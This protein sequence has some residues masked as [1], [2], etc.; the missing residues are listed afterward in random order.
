MVTIRSQSTR[1]SKTESERMERASDDERETSFPDILSREQMIELDSD[2]L[3]NRQRDT[4]RDVIDQRFYE[5]NRQIGELTNLVLALTLQ[6]SSNTREGNG[7]N[8]ATSSAN[9]HSETGRSSSTFLPCLPQSHF[10][11]NIQKVVRFHRYTFFCTNYQLDRLCVGSSVL[12]L[13]PIPHGLNFGNFLFNAF[14][15]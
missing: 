1:S 11:T 12:L 13:K 2:D 10:Y 14:F 15:I 6:I 4:K 5:M 3:L 7:L 9:S 8:M